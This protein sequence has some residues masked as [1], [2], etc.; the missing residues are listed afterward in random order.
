MLKIKRLDHVGVAVWKVDDAL[1]LFT[2]LF[3][4][5]LA[6]RFRSEEDGYQGV[7]LDI[8]GGTVQWELIEPTGDDTFVARFLQERGPGLHHVTFEV[9]DVAEAAEA[10]RKQ[11]IEPFRGVRE[12]AT[13]KET[14]IHPRDAGG[15]LVQ[16][17]EGE[18]S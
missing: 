15:V 18:W 12:E 11:G 6:G 8:A 7:T 17:Y 16:L 13:W 2:G 1:P 9:E 3:G 10:L 5:R 4:M 14:F